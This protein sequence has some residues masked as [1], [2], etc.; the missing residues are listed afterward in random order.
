VYGGVQREERGRVERAE[1]QPLGRCSLRDGHLE[2]SPHQD[3][4]IVVDREG[5]LG[6]EGSGEA[7]KRGRARQNDR[8]HP[9]S[10]AQGERGGPRRL[11]LPRFPASLLSVPASP[12]TFPA[13]PL[14]RVCCHHFGKY[15]M[16]TWV[17]IRRTMM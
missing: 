10:S 9:Q 5:G 14:P 4:A 6:V 17:A 16:A 15:S 13:S 11:S 1:H 12:P 2:G 3:P 8:C 7:G